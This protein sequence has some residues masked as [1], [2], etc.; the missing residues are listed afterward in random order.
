M[1][2]TSLRKSAKN[3]NGCRRCN[4]CRQGKSGSVDRIKSTNSSSV[5]KTR[6][7]NTDQKRRRMFWKRR[8]KRYEKRRKC[9]QECLSLSL[10]LEEDF[11]A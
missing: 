10:R 7:K 11:S 2:R 5:R 4:T 3:K 6:A 1:A 9:L 8:E